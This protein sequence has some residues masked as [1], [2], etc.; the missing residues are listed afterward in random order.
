M[1]ATRWVNLPSTPKLVDNGACTFISLVKLII[2]MFFEL[3]SMW[4]K[5]QNPSDCERTSIP[6]CARRTW[7]HRLKSMFSTPT[8]S[9]SLDCN[10]SEWR[11]RRFA[12][13]FS[14]HDQHKGQGK[15]WTFLVLVQPSDEELL[16]SYRDDG[17]KTIAKVDPNAQCSTGRCYYS[18]EDK[19][20]RDIIN[21]L[22]T[23]LSSGCDF[24]EFVRKL[25]KD[26]IWGWEE[27]LN[28]VIQIPSVHTLHCYSNVDENRMPMERIS[29]LH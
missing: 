22:A 17:K 13:M 24:H 28:K 1:R 11:A 9:G 18:V 29:G 27:L 10:S 26:I 2:G 21:C 12:V 20:L 15:S 8:A 6:Q 16:L 14:K 3:T 7:E 5:K 23:E 4:K 25:G 19:P